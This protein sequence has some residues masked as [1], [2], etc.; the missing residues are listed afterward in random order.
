MGYNLGASGG[1]CVR[2]VGFE[3]RYDY[4]LVDELDYSTLLVGLRWAF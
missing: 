4:R 2:R 3:V 1:Y